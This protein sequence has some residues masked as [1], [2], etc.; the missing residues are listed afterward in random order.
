MNNNQIANNSILQDKINAA[1]KLIK[2]IPKIPAP[3]KFIPNNFSNPII[4]KI[5]N[6]PELR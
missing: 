3:V 2:L 6:P 5:P 4:N 1:Q